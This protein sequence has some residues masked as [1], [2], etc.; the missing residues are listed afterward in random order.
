MR[1]IA[2]DIAG[3][4]AETPRELRK[5]SEEKAS[6]DEDAV[7]RT[8]TL[9]DAQK[10]F[11]EL[12]VYQVELE[13]QNEALRS[14]QRELADSRSR[15]F[16]LYDLA[17]V[18]YLTLDDQGV[19]REVNLA[20]ATMLGVLRGDLL[21]KP[22]TNYITPEDRSTCHQHLQQLY[23]ISRMQSWEMCMVR[24]DQIL[25]PVHAQATQTPD[26]EYRITLIDISDRR[27]AEDDLNL[28]F[29]LVP[30]MVC[31]ATLEGRFLKVNRTFTKTLGFSKHELMASSL[32]EL[33]HP[34]DR[35]SVRAEINKLF[36]G[37]H[38][39]RF[40]NRCRCKDGSH[41]WLE[42]MA[43]PVVDD[44]LVLYAAARDVT[45]RKQAESVLQARLRISDYALANSLEKLLTKILDEAEALTDSRIGFF[46]FVGAD[47]TTLSL[48]TWSSNTVATM[49]SAEGK[50]QHYPLE[51]A[52]VW[53]DCIRER[54]P[55]IHNDYESLPGRRGLPPGHAPVLREMV[56][57]IFRNNLIVA[58]LG[59]GN[60]Q[61]DYTIQE[62]TLLQH[63]AN[64]S[65]DIV[66]RKRAEDDQKNIE[67][68][69]SRLFESMTDA[70]VCTDMD[71]VIV[72]SNAM[73]QSMTGYSAEELSSLTYMQLTPKRWHA[74]EADILE[75]QVLVKGASEIY[76]KQYRKKDGTIIDVELK[77]YLLRD[78][79]GVPVGMWAIIGDITDRKQTERELQQAKETA[80]AASR[81][82][83]DF[84]AT[85]SHEIRT[86]LSAMLG[87]IELLE[88]SPLAPQQQEYLRDCKTAS[89][90]LF[91]VI[92]D[93]LDFS[94]IEAGKMELSF[95]VFSVASMGGQLA[96]MFSGVAEQKGLELVVRLAEDLPGYI[97]SD[98]QRLHQIIAN[99]LSNAIKFTRNGTVSLVISCEQPAVPTAPGTV[100]LRIVVSDTGIGIPPD[101][102]EHIFDSFTQVES[103]G[104][105][106]STGTG[107]GLA[108]CRR[109]L[110]LMCGTISVSSVPDAG[111]VF[112][113]E[114]PVT[115]AES[116]SQSQSQP[117]LQTLA[118]PRKVLLADDDSRGRMAAQKL[119]QRRGYLVTAVENGNSLLET[120]Q[121][122]TF[123]IVLTDISMPDIDGTRVARIIR[124][125]ERSGINP[126]IPIIA[127]TAHAFSDDR[128]RFLA[129][130][131]SG[132]VSKP[133]NLEELFRQIEEL[134]GG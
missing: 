63:L 55:L 45:E 23:K 18:G 83:S 8:L 73:Y 43:Q 13:M 105:R 6:F 24:G 84:L 134:C 10:L 113:V 33:I 64:L 78:D 106:T 80:E 48:Q 98:Q 91:Q 130:G 121:K 22:I 86:P 72:E 67:L 125:G 2:Q 35:E 97:R 112:T 107:L 59:V 44:A 68:K 3:R 111:S 102:Q 103:F 12:R 11:H 104:S 9:E 118:Q 31:I 120:L 4:S 93:I 49:C 92:N 60:K 79:R 15:Y 58:V 77:T 41:R 88:G 132:Y 128:E 122:E 46:H 29:D 96:R 21:N 71:G 28:F 87:N 70:Y 126:D 110:A 82:K 131:I 123:D 117:Q 32:P 133:V 56:V 52:G 61:S 94:K 90:M 20:V 38:S 25:L 101:K 26:G 114:L 76:Q 119:L 69:Y 39:R 42:W 54:R 37:G 85:M 30:D 5:I 51:S 62:R 36:S 65:W 16:N 109:L 27:K 47:Q 108:I 19:I 100:L 53:A 50:G 95:E 1:K 17:P 89:Q 57:P 129:A 81:A 74:V 99:L 75:K 7:L 34:D 124:S 115:L 40:I 116:P 14:A 127:M 66:K